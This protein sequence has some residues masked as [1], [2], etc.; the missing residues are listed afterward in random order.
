M[1]EEGRRVQGGRRGM[2]AHGGGTRQ[3]REEGGEEARRRRGE[4]ATRWRGDAAR[5]R[6]ASKARTWAVVFQ[7]EVLV[8]EPAAAVRAARAPAR[9]SR[10]KHGNTAGATDEPPDA[11]RGRKV[12]PQATK[13]T[14]S[15]ECIS[16]AAYAADRRQWQVMLACSRGEFW[17]AVRINSG[18][19]RQ[20]EPPE[21]N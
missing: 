13:H 12:G 15:S 6:E 1:G 10:T 9:S 3:D 2:E 4:E 21:D 7:L 16:S 14:S 18:S 19:D 17:Q 8:G 5:A 20:P 11:N